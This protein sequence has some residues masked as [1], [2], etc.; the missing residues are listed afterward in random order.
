MSARIGLLLIAS[1]VSVGVARAGEPARRAVAASP[2]LVGD[3]SWS[4]GNVTALRPDGTLLLPNDGVGSWRRVGPRQFE[5]R[6]EGGVARVELS[7]DGNLLRG[8]W[9]IPG[10]AGEPVSAQRLGAPAPA[11]PA[12]AMGP[13]PLDDDTFAGLLATVRA[14]ASDLSRRNLVIAALAGRTVTGDQLVALVETFRS[15]LNLLDVVRA[16]A[17][18]VVE[19]QRALGF[20]ARMR[21]SI[22][23]ERYVKLLSTGRPAVVAPPPPPPPSTSPPPDEVQYEPDPFEQP[24]AYLRRPRP[25]RPKQPCPKPIPC[26]NYCRYGYA[27][28]QNGCSSCACLPNPVQLSQ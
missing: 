13:T 19:P 18:R 15:E 17:P 24:G 8:V 26:A 3:W 20:A 16:V 5:V 1:T 14:T 6:Y 7:L 23:R 2:S 27:K 21:S 10:D 28:D 9:M 25:E 22:N 11:P 4:N 12:T